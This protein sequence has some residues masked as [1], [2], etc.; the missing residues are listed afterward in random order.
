MY[1][2]LFSSM[3]SALYIVIMMWDTH[4]ILY[5][6]FSFHYYLFETE[7]S[8]GNQVSDWTKVIV[9]SALLISNPLKLCL[10]ICHQTYL[11]SVSSC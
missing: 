5:F 2:Y 11:L 9:Y 8:L 10:F 3:H 4:T 6:H 7:D 1:R